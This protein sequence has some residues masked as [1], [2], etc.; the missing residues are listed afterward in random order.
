MVRNKQTTTTTKNAFFPCSNLLLHSHLLFLP[1]LGEIMAYGQLITAA[2]WCTFLLVISSSVGLLHMFLQ[3]IS[4]CSFMESF[5]SCVY[6]R[7]ALSSLLQFLMFFFF[8][9]HNCLTFRHFL[10]VFP[11]APPF[12]QT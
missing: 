4:S 12:W 1:T 5:K 6:S 10:N 7:V 11:G 9:P 3:E 8:T 2:L